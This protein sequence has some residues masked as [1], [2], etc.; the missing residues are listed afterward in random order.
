ML[1]VAEQPGRLLGKDIGGGDTLYYD[2]G[3]SFRKR[4]PAGTRGRLVHTVPFE[5]G[6]Y[7]VGEFEKV[8]HAGVSGRGSAASS[9]STSTWVCKINS[10]GSSLAGAR[11]R[12]Q[13]E[14]AAARHPRQ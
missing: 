8:V 13:K 12:Q 14:L 6:R 5:H 10:I 3:I 9:P 1:R 7:Q 11:P 2:G 4:D